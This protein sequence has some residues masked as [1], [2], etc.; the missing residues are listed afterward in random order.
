VKWIW[1]P[2]EDALHHAKAGTRL[3]RLRFSLL[4]QPHQ[5][6]IVITAKDHVSTWINGKLLL[7]SRRSSELNLPRDTWSYLRRV[8][9]GDL[10]TQGINTIAVEA[11]VEPPDEP[12]EETPAGM[13]VLLR[14]QMA[15]G[16]IESY[17]SGPDWKTANESADVNW[18]GNE[19]DDSAW[20]AAAPIP[21]ASHQTLG[22]PLPTESP[23]L[24]R[25]RFE[26]SQRIRSAHVYSTALG[27]YQLY[28]NGQRVGNNV[29][30][31]GWTDYA[32]HIV[33][34]I[35]D[36]TVASAQGRECTW[37]NPR[38]WLVRRWIE[39]ET[40]TLQLWSTSSSSSYNSR[41][42]TW[43]ALEM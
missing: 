26:V 41:L 43:M 13:I 37:C 22:T 19:F 27:S 20:I 3:F 10:L 5:A 18:F 6:T 15:D 42:N 25:R 30:A 32:K 36:V 35:Y 11:T 9:V 8:S 16:E 14:V 39:L 23:N 31:P 33:Y 28:L 1:G 24:F 38:R 29:L 4:F 2:G 21:N 17:A 34:Q 40:D 7:D 12:G